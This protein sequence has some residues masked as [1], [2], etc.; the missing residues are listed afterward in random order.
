MLYKK[1]DDFPADSCS[2]S[3]ELRF[4][5]SLVSSIEGVL[6]LSLTDSKR[7]MLF[8][9]D[10]IERLSGYPVSDFIGDTKKPFIG[11]IHPEERSF[12]LEMIDNAKG[13]SKSFEIEYRLISSDN[14]TIWILDRGIRI[15][16]PVDGKEHI[17][18]LMIDVTKRKL[19]EGNLRRSEVGYR[20]LLDNSDDLVY[21]FDL[22]PQR[23]Y[24]YVSNSA[25][26]ITGY[27]PEE[28]YRDSDLGYKLIHPEDRDLFEKML[29]GDTVKAKKPIHLRWIKRNGTVIWTEQ[30]NVYLCNKNGELTA[31]EGV[32]RD[33][34]ERK[35]AEE[36][37]SFQNSYQRLVSS[38]ASSFVSAGKTD[39]EVRLEE[40]LSKVSEL[41]RVDRSYL[42]LY[43]KKEDAF[44]QKNAWV[45]EG[46]DSNKGQ[47]RN[48]PAKNAPW[49]VKELTYKPYVYVD[50][51]KRLS[52]N[53]KLRKEA[54][55]AKAKSLLHY[56]LLIEG[57]L[58]GL[59]TF[60][61]A[62]KH[63]KWT[64]EEL[65][66]LGVVVKLCAEVVHRL[67]LQDKKLQAEQRATAMAM[68]VTANHEIN[69]PLMIIQGYTELIRNQMKGTEHQ[70]ALNR[71]IKAV[72]RIKEILKSLNHIKE[73]EFTD[74]AGD[75]EM[76]KL[77]QR[78]E[79]DS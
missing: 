45:A 51:E 60:V 11:L 12:V 64:Q 25:I 49:F 4:L 35:E 23:G 57:N 26:K 47:F 54:G 40:A 46:V 27:T 5:K 70:E 42:F 62:T 71:I 63:K 18:G 2:V 30:K 13:K 65:L 50:I 31:I 76:I 29:Q 38:I 24:A 41:F 28:H 15:S 39:L 77:P 8:I 43:S 3:E 61:Q 75:R 14:R 73:V 21:R 56:P 79:V 34:T 32:V 20:R 33:I 17:K 52:E 36:Y 74:Y 72:A 58:L 10:E 53:E 59:I 48:I 6:Y 78:D 37:H 1:G 19:A 68:T 67:E 9:S 55:I 7:T 44:V 16:D 22:V 69:Q 66:Q